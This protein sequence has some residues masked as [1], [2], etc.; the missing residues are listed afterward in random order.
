VQYKFYVVR[1]NRA[2]SAARA[3]ALNFS[4]TYLIEHVNRIRSVALELDG[5][6]IVS[7]T[8]CTSVPFE[9][10]FLQ[11]TIFSWSIGWCL[12]GTGLSKYALAC[13]R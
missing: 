10:P 11:E 8:R 9:G 1:Y 3:A 12:S 7:C 6:T 5:T 4:A 13:D 2:C